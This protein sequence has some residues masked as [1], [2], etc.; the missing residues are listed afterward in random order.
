MSKTNGTRYIYIY[1]YITFIII[2]LKENSDLYLPSH[3]T[4]YFSCIFFFYYQ[5]CPYY[6]CFYGLT[7]AYALQ[8]DQNT[9]FPWF[10]CMSCLFLYLLIIF[11]FSFCVY[12]CLMISILCIHKS[13][14]LM[15]CAFNGLLIGVGPTP[16]HYKCWA[17]PLVLFF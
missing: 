13:W 2:R 14:S 10:S 7:A 12:M 1:I 9:P 5:K 16:L 3:S 11:W 8:V 17:I 15:I 6:P 4:S